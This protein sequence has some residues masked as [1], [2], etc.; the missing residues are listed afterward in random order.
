MA[1][2]SAAQHQAHLAAAAAAAARFR[3]ASAMHPHAV[4]SG[5]MPVNAP[6]PIGHRFPNGLSLPTHS[7]MNN[8]SEDL[9][10]NLESMSTLF[11]RIN[12]S[13]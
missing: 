6:Y 5:R 12:L 13:I 10:P 11:Q 7:A 3:A 8:S 4:A 9:K 2:S 1:N